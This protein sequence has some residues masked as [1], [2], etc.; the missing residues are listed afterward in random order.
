MGRK[1]ISIGGC[2]A[3]VTNDPRWLTALAIGSLWNL[4]LVLLLPA[5]ALLGHGAQVLKA[6]YR[7]ERATI[8][9][10]TSFG[11]LLL[12]GLRVLGMMAVHYL[13]AGAA[14]WGLVL[15]ITVPKP[16]TG[17]VE[18]ILYIGAMSSLV[19]FAVLAFWLFGLYV[20][21]AVGR[22]VVLDRWTA[23]FE[24]ARNLD[25]IRRNAANYAR[26]VAIVLIGTTLLQFSP[27]LCCVGLLPAAFW[28]QCTMNYA[29]GRLLASDPA[30]DL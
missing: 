1:A 22:A 8:P 2:L 13:I 25:C 28:V 15:A 30:L 26:F 14:M 10:W 24:V 17:E 5:V 27:L 12:D 3:W 18:A 23:G 4:A 29:L 7:D 16:P 20:L 21:T 9:G 6:S 11:P 19:G